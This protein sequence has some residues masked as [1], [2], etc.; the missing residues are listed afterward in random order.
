MKLLCI[1]DTHG[2]HGQLDLSQYSA[3]VLIHAGDWTK[4]RD[5][6]FVETEDFLDWLAEQPFKDKVLI[7]GNH[8]NSVDFNNKHF[9]HLLSKERYSSITYLQDSSTIIDGV[10]FYG[11]P[12]SNTFGNWAFMKYDNGLS[13]IWDN[14][15]EDTNVLITHGPA[16]LCNDKVNNSWSRDANVGSESLRKRKL[17]L[18]DLKVHISG[19]IHEAY[20]INNNDGFVNICPS[21]LNERYELVNKPIITIIKKG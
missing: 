17:L 21:V 15:D 2:K 4:G 3:D 14:I 13:K 1:S 18:P 20:G 7:A 12:Y 11:S 10:K 9:V 8:E 16:Y 6:G 5:I 19:H